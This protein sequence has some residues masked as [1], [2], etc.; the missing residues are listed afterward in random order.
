MIKEHHYL[1]LMKDVDLGS[2]IAENDNLL[3]SARVELSV[4]GQLFRD[5]I[6][7][8]RGTKG[9]G[10]SAIYQLFASHFV[11]H[12]LNNLG[13]IRFRGHLPKG[14]YDVQ[15]GIKAGGETGAPTVQ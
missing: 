1:E 9:S 4:F 13:L 6:D 10:K 15:N 7:I 14:G 12:L 8:I 2:P 3:Y 11:D 5:E